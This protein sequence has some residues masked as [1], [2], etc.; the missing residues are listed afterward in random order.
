MAPLQEISASEARDRVAKGAVLLDVREPFELQ[1][2]SVKGA[3]AIPMGQIPAR[4]GELDR[5]RELVCMCH[6]GMRS[7]NVAGY[8]LQNGFTRVLNLSGGIA[9]WA[10]EVDPSVPQY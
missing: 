10:A 3:L 6:H 7:A 2:A 8:L 1:V 4:L 5:G 9:A